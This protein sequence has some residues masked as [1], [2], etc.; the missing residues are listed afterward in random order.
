[1]VASLGDFLPARS[2]LAADAE[3]LRRV[4]DDYTIAHFTVARAF[5]RELQAVGGKYIFINGPLAFQPWPDSAADLVSIAT[6]AQHMLFRALSQELAAG[7][8]EVL[9][10]VVYTYVRRR[11]TQPGSAVSAEAIGRYVSDLLFDDSQRR[12]GESIHLRTAEQAA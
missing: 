2:L 11:E 1:V 12:H 7:P 9:E 3:Q 6:A 10:L 4:L 8:A 5:L